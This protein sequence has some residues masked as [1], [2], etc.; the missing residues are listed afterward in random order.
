VS[1]RD[2]R[3]VREGAEDCFFGLWDI[4]SVYLY[5]N[6][7]KMLPWG[8]PEHPK[9]LEMGGGGVRLFFVVGRVLF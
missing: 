4:G 1:C 3:V 6:E 9:A 2:D 7:H 5:S 8:T